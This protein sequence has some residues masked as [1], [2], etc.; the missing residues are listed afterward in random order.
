MG[1]VTSVPFLASTG[2]SSV[3]YPV[4]VAVDGPARDLLPGMTA[5]LTIVT[6]QVFNVPVVPITAVHATA[7][8]TFV[9][10]VDQHN[11]VAQVRVRIGI[12]D[13]ISSQIL[14]GLSLGQ[15]I[16][17]SYSPGGTAAQ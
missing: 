17:L 5:N 10:S 1:K 6:A 13:S 8:G 11:R 9:D 15:R 4:Q 14:A 3:T 16:L 12:G 2:S 7:T